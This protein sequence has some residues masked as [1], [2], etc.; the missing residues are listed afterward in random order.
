MKPSYEFRKF[1]LVFFMGML[2]FSLS[3]CSKPIVRNESQPAGYPIASDVQTTLQRTIV[4]GPD[5]FDGDQ[6]L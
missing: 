1:C 3:A 5:T 6:S 2:I 4:P